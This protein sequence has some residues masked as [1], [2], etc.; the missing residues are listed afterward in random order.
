[1]EQPNFKVGMVLADARE[2]REALK[3]YR[4]KERV[5]IQ[6]VRNE[7]ARLDDVCLGECPGGVCSWFLKASEDNRKEAMV[8]RK[9]HGTHRCERVWELKALTTSFL[10]NYF[11]DEF[12][13]N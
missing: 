11:I 8:V 7:T 5:K 2:L 10:T 13:D 4:V 12:R 9:Y 3:D 6:K 1:M